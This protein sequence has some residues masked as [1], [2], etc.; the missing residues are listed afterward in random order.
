V[1]LSEKENEEITGYVN[2]MAKDGLRVLGI[3][4]SQFKKAKLPTSQHDFD[5]E[6][7]G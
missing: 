5:F 1:H 6:F 7:L 4:K 2:V 3:A